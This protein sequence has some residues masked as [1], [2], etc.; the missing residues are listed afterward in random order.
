MNQ[1]TEITVKCPEC[2]LEYRP[3]EDKRVDAGERCCWCSYQAETAKA[4][5]NSMTKGELKAN[6]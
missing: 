1:Q 2:E 4:K 6:V 5:I 3:G